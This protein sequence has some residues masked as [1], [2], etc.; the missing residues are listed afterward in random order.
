[1]VSSSCC[2]ILLV[3]FF[4]ILAFYLVKTVVSIKQDLIWALSAL[5]ALTQRL[6]VVKAD[7]G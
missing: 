7:I 4:H 6:Y 5:L 3:F 2:C 1:M